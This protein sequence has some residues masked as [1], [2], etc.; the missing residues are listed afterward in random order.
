[1]TEI[2]DPYAGWY[3][4]H[5]M[6]AQCRGG[7]EACLTIELLVVDEAYASVGVDPSWGERHTAFIDK[8][9]YIEYTEGSTVWR[10]YCDG[11]NTSQNLASI[12]IC[13]EESEDPDTPPAI[14]NADEMAVG[15]SVLDISLVR[16]ICDK[17]QAVIGYGGRESTIGH[18]MKALI[19][20]PSIYVGIWWID[21]ACTKAYIVRADTT[22]PEHMKEAAKDGAREAHP[23]ATPDEIDEAYDWAREMASRDPRWQDCLENYRKGL[24]TYDQFLDCISAIIN[25]YLNIWLSQ[26]DFTLSIPTLLIAGETTASGTTPQPNQKLEIC[27]T[28][29]FFGFDF[30]AA[31]EVLATVTSDADYN[32]EATLNLDEFGIIEVYAR[33]PQDWWNVLEKNLTTTKHTVCVLTW[34]IILFLIIAA[35]L[36]YEKS[37]GKLG[38]LKKRR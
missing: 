3:G 12:R 16:L 2:C 23:S 21:S 19:V 14:G 24:I 38:L 28:K 9:S 11:V 22:I 8:G 31:D 34:M 18:V 10:V 5:H 17:A 25:E 29:K 4:I 1:M 35:A 15:D 32:Y 30:L 13:Y 7:E 33:I 37:T 26:K 20:N 6:W 27:A 36:I